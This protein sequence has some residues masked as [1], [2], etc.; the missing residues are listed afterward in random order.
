MRTESHHMSTRLQYINKQHLQNT[1]AR[2]QK[3]HRPTFLT[4]IG[5]VLFFIL[6][7]FHLQCTWPPKCLRDRDCEEKQLCQQQQCVPQNPSDASLNPEEQGESTTNKN[8]EQPTFPEITLDI[9]RPPPPTESKNIGT[10]Q[11]L[12]ACSLNPW[13]LPPEQCADGL[14]CIQTSA[15]TAVCMRACD[16]NPSRCATESKQR[17]FCAHVGVLRRTRKPFYACV[18]Y[19]QH[20]Q[21]CNPNQA[22]LCDPRQSPHL[23]CINQICMRGKRLQANQTCGQDNRTQCDPLEQLVC[24]PQNNKC[25]KGIISYDADPCTPPGASTA[26]PQVCEKGYT[27]T[28]FPYGSGRVYHCIKQCSLQ[29]PFDSCLGTLTHKGSQKTCVAYGQ[30]NLCIQQ[31]CKQSS[32]C[33]SS[34]HA[35]QCARYVFD[36]TKNSCL[37]APTSGT[38]TLNEPCQ[39]NSTKLDQLCK[40]PYFCLPSPQS[41]P[42]RGYCTLSC[43]EDRHCQ[44]LA[45]NSICTLRQ[46]VSQLLYCAYRCKNQKDCPITFICNTESRICYPP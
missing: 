36:N 23:I 31:G 40:H 42:P 46:N 13:S 17:F 26:R 2:T 41:N 43:L 4:H 9:V 16:D 33:A 37:P 19:A 38:R 6:A 25:I 21:T 39:V 27:C 14:E 3:Q 7:Y 44:P 45:E 28:A 18:R 35:Y 15:N 8:R 11:E 34:H 5:L 20:K 30:L 24:N 22:T 12:Q 1:S 32:E 29:N 10:Q